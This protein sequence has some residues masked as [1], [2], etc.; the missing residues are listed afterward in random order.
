MDISNGNVYIPGYIRINLDIH[1]DLIPNQYLW[2]KTATIIEN[3]EIQG[4]GILL[5]KFIK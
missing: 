3:W 4:Y 5:Y 1:D 2:K